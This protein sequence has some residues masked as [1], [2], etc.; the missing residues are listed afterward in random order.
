MTLD[1]TIRPFI[2]TASFRRMQQ[3]DQHPAPFHAD[4]ELRFSH[5]DP[6]DNESHR[7][8][9]AGGDNPFRHRYA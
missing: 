1:E 7:D 6:H 5:L 3:L 4:F 8:R 9:C 2:G